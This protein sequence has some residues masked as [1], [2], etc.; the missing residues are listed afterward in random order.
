[1]ISKLAVVETTSIGMESSIAEFVVIRSGVTIGDNVTIHPHVVIESGV[2]IEDGVEIFPGTYIGKSPKGAGATSRPISFKP[3]VRIGRDCA[4]GPNAVIYYEVE[5]GNNTLIG[6]GA[7]IR[8]QVTIGHH[9]IISR[10]VT[11]NYA[12][13]IGNNTKIMDL[14]HITGKCHIG[15][16]VFIG[17]LVSTANDNNL[18]AREYVEEEIIG[19]KVQDGATI[20]S[21]TTVLPGISIGEGAL[22]GA[23]TLV[24]RDVAP[25]KLA[26]GNP[27]R[28]IK[29]L[30]MV[31]P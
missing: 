16:N 15:D 10:Y 20:G 22:V 28:I 18:V 6:D 14:T 8:D 12:S 26:M 31:K 25:Y 13:Q 5:I 4:I 9:C 2:T 11:I 7:S 30:R 17:M 27:A 3:W 1:M 23:Q 19:P 24:S 29:D 21:G